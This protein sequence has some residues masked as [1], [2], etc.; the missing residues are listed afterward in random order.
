MSAADSSP[1]GGP[2]PETVSLYEKW[3]KIYPLFS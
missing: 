1:T 2:V 3:R